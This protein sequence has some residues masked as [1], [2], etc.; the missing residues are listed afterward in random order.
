MVCSGSSERATRCVACS[1][2]SR[3]CRSFSSGSASSTPE[4]AETAASS[5]MEASSMALYSMFLMAISTPYPAAVSRAPPRGAAPGTGTGTRGSPE[6]SPEIAEPAAAAP[7]ATHPSPCSA[8][9]ASRSTGRCTYRTAP[10]S[11]AP[12]S[13]SWNSRSSPTR[14]TRTASPPAAPGAPPSSPPCFGPAS[15]RAFASLGVQGGRGGGGGV[16]V[17]EAR[18]PGDRIRTAFREIAF[19]VGEH[20]TQ[21]REI[22]RERVSSAREAARGPVSR[23]RLV[24]FW[25]L[26]RDGLRVLPRDGAEHLEP[27]RVPAD[28]QREL[29]DPMSEVGTRHLRGDVAHARRA[30]GEKSVGIFILHRFVARLGAGG[31][32]LHERPVR[33]VALV[34]EEFRG[35]QNHGRGLRGGQGV[36]RKVAGPSGPPGRSGKG[37]SRRLRKLF[38]VVNDGRD[39]PST[40]W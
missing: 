1:P 22:R 38:G 32:G 23:R 16:G 14:A 21:R 20:S 28:P 40:P 13:A 27:R 5:P 36:S 9:A 4:A 19:Q 15:R 12:R 18:Y 39:V 7:S 24:G 8:H 10:R 35:L 30:P 2:K 37:I 25:F 26:S 33:R 29:Q 34:R 3:I 31:P 6:A 17:I 11:A